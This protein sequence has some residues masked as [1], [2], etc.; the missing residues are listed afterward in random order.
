MERIRRCRL[1][2]L[3]AL[4]AALALPAG[5]APR[6]AAAK[7]LQR[8]ATAPL[9]GTH[10]EV[11]RFAAEV[12][13]RRGLPH[14]WLAMQLAT[15]RRIDSVRK[16]VM[17]PPAG[18]AK[19]WAA[20]RA[21]FIEPRRIEAGVAF[22]QASESALQRAE[23][24]YGVPAEVV[25]GII[26]VETFYGRIMGSHRIIDALATLAFDFP[27]G[28]SD[29][30]AFFRAELE[31]FFVLC[32]REG[33]DPQ[34]VRGSYAGAMGLPQFM[35]GSINRWAVDHDGDGRVDLHASAADAV[36]SVAHYLQSYGWQTGLPTHFEVTPPADA[37]DRAVLL[38]PDILPSFSAAQFAERGAVLAEPGAGHGG[39]LALVELHNGEVSPS[40]VAGTQNFYVVTRYNQS[41]YYA[42][43][44]IEL[45][46]AVAAARAVS[47][48]S[49]A[50]PA[51]PPPCAG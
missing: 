42:L 31:E 8:P 39:P 51:P 21:R 35:P 17:P 38:G 26:G 2:G 10:D 47:N 40:H 25:V 27:A 7:P 14:E 32:A 4:C 46:R 9:Y 34:S 15:A 19:N 50:A 1:V 3:L 36:G 20:Y 12:A 28:R 16:L 23:Q 5:A 6:K 22:W 43:A 44:V 33:I 18:T 11:L 49:A 29:R 37:A 13:Q 41:S 48:L 30:S 45:G 24:R